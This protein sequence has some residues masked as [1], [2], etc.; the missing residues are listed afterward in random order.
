MVSEVLAVLPWMIL[1]VAI[2]VIPYAFSII[3]A[4]TVISPGLVSILYMTEISADTI[5]AAI[6][7]GEVVGLREIAGVVLVSLAGLLE[8]VCKMTGREIA[9]RA[10]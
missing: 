2:M 3:W 4:A 10:V 1:V 7:A 6:W 8:P 9:W 5:T